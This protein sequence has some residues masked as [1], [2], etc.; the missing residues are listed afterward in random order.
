M[1]PDLSLSFT[2][3]GVW[4][5]SPSFDDLCYW[6]TGMSVA[7]A[8]S[9]SGKKLTHTNERTD[10]RTNERDG[11]N[12]QTD[13]SLSLSGLSVSQGG[14]FVRGYLEKKDIVFFEESY[15]PGF[16]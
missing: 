15:H 12:E 10:E 2:G 8:L 14:K 6:L 5:M 11:K 9:F 7:L 3:P 4:S 13:L 16:A 1:E